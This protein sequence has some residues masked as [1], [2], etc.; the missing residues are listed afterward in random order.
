[1]TARPSEAGG[2]DLDGGPCFSGETT[3]CVPVTGLDPRGRHR[4]PSTASRAGLSGAAAVLACVDPSMPRSRT[5]TR[6]KALP[7]EGDAERDLDRGD[8]APKADLN[9]A[10]AVLEGIRNA[11]GRECPGPG[12]NSCGLRLRNPAATDFA[13]ETRASPPPGTRSSSPSGDLVAAQPR[14]SRRRSAWRRRSG[15]AP[16]AAAKPKEVVGSS[17]RL[18]GECVRTSRGL[19]SSTAAPVRRVRN[20]EEQTFAAIWKSHGEARD[21]LDAAGEAAPGVQI[22][23]L[24]RVF[25]LFRRIEPAQAVPVDATR[26]VVVE[27]LGRA[28]PR[29]MRPTQPTKLTIRSGLI[30][31]AWIRAR[32]PPPIQLQVSH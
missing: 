23:G 12:R 27:A 14:Q 16:S 5:R 26:V 11:R 7:P 28:L 3:A 25:R 8:A 19:R 17:V 4:R 2:A 20:I 6:S 9:D 31:L 18:G 15:G 21:R 10:N 30:E 1:M 32:N 22:G 24:E 29:H 13:P